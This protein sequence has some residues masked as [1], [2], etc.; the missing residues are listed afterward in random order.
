MTPK[1]MD[2]IQNDNLSLTYRVTQGQG[3]QIDYSAEEIHHT[4][5][6]G[7]NGY[8]GDSPVMDVRESIARPPWSDD[9]SSGRS[10]LT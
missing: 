9:P 6:T 2:V 4:R 8:V 7:R 3:Q 1:R 5:L 10:V